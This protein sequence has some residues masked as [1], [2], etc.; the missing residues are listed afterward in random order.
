MAADLAKLL[1]EVSAGAES[2]TN[3]AATCCQS[4][5][6]D[7]IDQDQPRGPKVVCTSSRTADAAVNLPG[8]PMSFVNVEQLMI[9]GSCCAHS[10]QSWKGGT[11]GEP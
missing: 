6:I 2:A 9:A 8:V 5:S 1:K 10:E 11:F 3:P 4:R 7:D